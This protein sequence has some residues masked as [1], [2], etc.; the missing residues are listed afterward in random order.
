MFIGIVLEVRDL[1]KY[2]VLRGFYVNGKINLYLIDYKISENLEDLELDLV[3]YF[4]WL[5]SIELNGLNEG[6]S[7]FF[8][9]YYSFCVLFMIVGFLLSS[10][11]EGFYFIFILFL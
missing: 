4:I 8:T 3:G 1:E 5:L 11:Y 6:L 10:F 7:M 2:K 9:Y